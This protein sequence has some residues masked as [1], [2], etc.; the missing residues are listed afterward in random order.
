MNKI[1]TF[2][3]YK[4]GVGRSMALAN[5]A[6]LLSQ[7]G[8]KV[9]M[10]DFDLEAPGLQYFFKKYIGNFDNISKKVG[11]LN[12]LNQDRNNISIKWQDL[13]TEI[14]IKD[15]YEKLSLITSGIKDE[16]YLENLKKFNV[17][18]FYENNNGG[19]IIEKLREEWKENFDFIFIDSRTGVTDIGG[20]CTIQFPDILV[21]LFTTT[22]QGL[23]GTMEVA[24]KAR[25]NHNNLPFDRP[26]LKILPIP[27]RIDNSEVELTEKWLIDFSKKIDII[28]D[29]WLDIDINRLDFIK[30]IFIPYVPYDSFGETLPV[31]QDTINP[32]RI[33][34]SITSIASLLANEMKDSKLFFENRDSL[35]N[36]IKKQ[37]S[38]QKFSRDIYTENLNIQKNKLENIYETRLI[39]VG[40]GGAGKTSLLRKLLDENAVLPT[41]EETTRGIDIQHYEFKAADGRTFRLHLWD[42]G[43]Q[44]IYHATHQPLTSRSHLPRNSRS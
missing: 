2:Y 40:E 16:T 33:G 24:Q 37:G 41:E 14:R 4:G 31:V 17:A 32:L 18:E 22:N 12:Y 8:F 11:I 35:I 38:L 26:L 13:I 1:L 10:V 36:S 39:I 5:T 42:F 7:W 3:S 15:E 28:V 9:L 43:G 6:V 25:T 21:T 23:E 19:Q 34:Y 27:T 30:K 44:E 20:I 29:N